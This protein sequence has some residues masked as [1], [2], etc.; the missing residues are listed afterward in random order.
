MLLGCLKLPPE[1][2]GTPNFALPPDDANFA[3]PTDAALRVDDGAWSS[4]AA[5]S[6]AKLEL[7][8]ILDGLILDSSPLSWRHKPGPALCQPA[9]S[10]GS[11]VS[12]LSRL[13]CICSR[14][15]TV[16][17][18]AVVAAAAARQQQ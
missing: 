11:R 18:V 14:S 7:V 17:V 16:A 1:L 9:G 13:V 3:L 12:L 8:N 5:W 4:S 2:L 6:E 10:T 15:H